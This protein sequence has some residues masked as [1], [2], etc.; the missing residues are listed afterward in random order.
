LEENKQALVELQA[1]Q[2]EFA[3]LANEELEAY[4]E[5]S[6]NGLQLKD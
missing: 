1:L 6:F 4:L 5:F 2:K 3:V